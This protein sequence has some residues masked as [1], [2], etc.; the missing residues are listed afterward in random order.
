MQ[1]LI[2]SLNTSIH[3]IKSFSDLWHCQPLQADQ[4]SQRPAGQADR[5]THPR[6]HPP[7]QSR[8]RYPFQGQRLSGMRLSPYA[9]SYSVFLRSPGILFIKS[10]EPHPFQRQYPPDT[11]GRRSTSRTHSVPKS[12]THHD[13]DVGGKKNS[14]PKHFYLCS[15]FTASIIP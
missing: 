11:A 10:N 3:I 5:L 12:C 1:H 8:P 2:Y 14:A 15:C 6:R 9:F 4:D 7:A 13:M